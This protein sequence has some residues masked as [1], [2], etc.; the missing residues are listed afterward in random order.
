MRRLFLPALFLALSISA[1]SAARHPY[2]FVWAGDDDKKASDF[3]AVIDAD[4]ASPAYGSVVATTPT[5]TAGAV[6]H[7]TEDMVAA[8]DHLLAN[9][10]DSGRTWLFDLHRPLAPRILTSFG[11]LAGYNHPHSYIRLP[12]GHVLATFQYHGEH[13]TGG[14]VEL[15]ERGTVIRSGSAVDPSAPAV[16]IEPYSVL[17]L[18]ALDRALSTD[19]SMM[20]FERRHGGKVQLWRLSDLTLLRTFDLPPGPKGNENHWSG[21]PR[22]LPD[23]SVYIHTFQCG[24]YHLTGLE[25]SSPHAALVYTFA[26]QLCA[27]PIVTGHWWLQTVPA[28]HAVVVLDITDPAH[29]RE[30]ARVTLDDKQQP[31]WIALAPG[32]RRIVINSGEYGEH[33][34]F[35]ADFDP[36]TGKLTLDARF[37]DRGSDRPGVSMD[38]KTWPHGFHG[39]AYPHG[40]VFSR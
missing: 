15:D 27:V 40:A 28:A 11:D 20:D 35:I 5:G 17:A 10:F 30:V 21:E 4:P 16:V 12:N 31:H 24:L 39:N 32:G 22:L 1:A 6:P 13:Q 25:N 37:R 8:N 3:L 19:T 14:L 2:L 9:G 38:G 34:L 33:R 18:P 26:G 29:P 36:Q 7:H 23:G